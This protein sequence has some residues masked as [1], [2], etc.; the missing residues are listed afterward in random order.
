MTDYNFLME[1]RLSPEQY[2][3]VLALSRLAAQEG[4]NL[5]LAGEAVRDLTLGRPLIRTLEF[6]VEGSPKRILR[7]LPVAGSGKVTSG[8]RTP[9]SDLKPLQVEQL[10]Y[11]KHFEAATIRFCNGVQAEVAMCRQES[12]TKPGYRPEI[13]PAS[14]F[15]DLKRRDFS[16]NAMAISLHPNSRGLLLDPTNGAADI[17]KR[18]LRI[19]RPRGFVEDPI[20]VYRLLRLRLQLDFKAEERTKALFD[21]ALESRAWE[22][23]SPRQQGSELRAILEPDDPGRVLKSLSELGLLAGLDSQLAGARIPFERFAKVRS[24]VRSIPGADPLLLN[25][26]ALVEKLGRNQQLRLAKKI[27]VELKTVRMA[28]GMPAEARRLARVLASPKVARPSQIY[29]LLADKPRPLLLYLLVYCLQKKVQTRVRSFLLKYLPLRARL[30]RAELHALG[31]K[32][33]PEFDKILDRVFFDQLD[34]KI[35]TRQQLLKQLRTLARFTES[36]PKLPARRPTK[37]RA[38]GQRPRGHVRLAV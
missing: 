30:P 16:V 15:D 19:L 32:P 24:V 36:P 33:G 2:Q 22:R 35:K 21:A 37:I 38:K 12:Y 20:R 3:V 4:M 8:S 18:E 23:I 26:H 28:I 13:S 31:L 17:E 11:D 27:L 7:H 5:Y 6:V 14:I 29:L 25:F 9:S 1:S 10:R 34:G